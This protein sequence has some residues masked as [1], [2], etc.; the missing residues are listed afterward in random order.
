MT[1]GSVFS[2]SFIPDGSFDLLRDFG[3]DFIDVVHRTGMFRGLSQDILFG[4]PSSHEITA[5]HDIG[6]A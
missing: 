5:T 1:R 2:G 4:I 3:C 6:T